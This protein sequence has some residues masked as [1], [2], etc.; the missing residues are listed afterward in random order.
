MADTRPIDMQALRVFFTTAPDCNMSKV[1]G[2]LGISQ[3]AVSQSIRLLEEEF[4]TPLLNR[5]GR[6]LKLTT[7]G[8]ALLNRGRALLEE[9]MNL[10]GAVIEA[11]KGIKPSLRVGLV[12]SFAATC[13]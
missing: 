8:M 1:A 10:R 3:S 6:P 7:A 13:G 2:R 4:G 9:A 11:S 12:D 5:S